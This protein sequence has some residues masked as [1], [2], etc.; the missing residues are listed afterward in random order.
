[1]QTKTP[2]RHF[3]E[4]AFPV[5]NLCGGY[6]T[7]TL[8]ISTKDSKPITP[9]YPIDFSDKSRLQEMLLSGDSPSRKELEQRFP[10]ATKGL[11]E[12]AE[13][14]NPDEYWTPE[15]VEEYWL[16]EHNKQVVA[17]CKIYFKKVIEPTSKGARIKFSEFMNTNYESQTPT[18]KGDIISIHNKKIIEVLT[19]EQ[20][21][22]Y[23]PEFSTSDRNASVYN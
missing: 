23:A 20:I 8:P 14:Q 15:N 17:L 21:E 9:L 1:M 18:K 13:T 7:I 2:E 19:P 22:K 3:F 12:L 11:R 6:H 5:I 16:R 4:Y 10:N